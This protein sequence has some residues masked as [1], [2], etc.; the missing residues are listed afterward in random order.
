MK[1]VRYSALFGILSGLAVACTPSTSVI[2]NDAIRLNQLGYYPNQEKIAVV[3][4][5]KVEE[6]VI[7]DAVSGEQVFAGK[8]LYTA[9]SEWSDKTR[10]T[11]DFSAVTTPGKYILKVNGA[12]VTFLIKD[13]VLSP[14]ADAAL[15]SFYY[16]RTAMPIEEQYAGQWHRMAGH[17]DNHVL[18][19]PSAASPDRPAGTI[20]SSSKGWYDAGDYNKYIV[21]S[22][23][24]IGLIQ[25]IYQLF[26]DYF[27]R[28]KINIPESNNHT[29]DLLDEMQFNLD[30][31]LTMQDPEDGGVYHKLTTPFLKVL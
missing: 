27:S 17:P 19:H 30:W 13:S 29:P 31:L 9:K 16:Q 22:G 20:V 3:D 25:S 24:S 6:F 2:P 11:L 10:T 21:N 28:Q 8:S 14:L 5:G 23:Y 7:W 4:S 26:P 1:I 15:K 18:I 12:S